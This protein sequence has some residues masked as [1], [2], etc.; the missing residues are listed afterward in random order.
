MP[1]GLR[2]SGLLITR[3]ATTAAIQAMATLENRPSTRSSAWNTFSSISSTA[4]RAL[5]SAH[6]SRPGWLWVRRAKK[7]DHASEPA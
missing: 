4:I 5:N 3:S 7:F 2:P 6:T 1:G